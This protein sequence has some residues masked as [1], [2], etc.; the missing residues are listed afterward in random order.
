[1][2]GIVQINHNAH[3][4][5]S[6]D[7][8]KPTIYSSMMVSVA[9]VTLIHAAPEIQKRHQF[10]MA[11]LIP[12]VEACV[13]PVG[14]ARAMAQSPRREHMITQGCEPGERGLEF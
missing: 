14:P 1:M 4:L 5:A 3:A 8:A 9:V 13:H 12:R 6:L 7:S 10:G 11:E 2:G